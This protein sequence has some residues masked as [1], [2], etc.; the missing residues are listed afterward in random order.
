[1]GWSYRKSFGSGPF[2]VNF[3]KSG[4]SYSLG[5]KGA[6]LNVGPRGTFVN[7]SSHGISY[8]RK[9]SSPHVPDAQ[10]GLPEV[11]VPI[12]ESHNI[13][14]AEIGQ[15][16]DTDSKDFIDELTQKSARASYAKW[17]GYFPLVLFLMA[18]LFTS[19]SSQT[20]VV[21]PASDSTWVRITS[22]EG[23]NI[24][25]APSPKSDILKAGSYGQTFPLQDNTN[26]RWFK[27]ALHDSAGYL[28]KRFGSIVPVHHDE[29]TQTETILA[30]SYAPYELAAGLLIFVFLIRWL[31]K[32]DRKRFQVDL[33]YEMDEQFQKVYEQFGK[34]FGS[35]AAS[36]RIWQYLNASATSDWKRTGGAGRLIKR[37][38]VRGIHA[39]LAP[40]PYF[41]TNVHIPCIKLS[42][43]EFYFMP[44]RL[45]VKRGDIFAAV[46]YKNLHVSGTVIRFIEDEGAPGDARIVDQTWRYVN[47]HGGPDRRFNNNRQI[48]VCAYSEYSITSDTGIYE[49][50]TTS[51]QGAMDGFAEFLRQIGQLQSRMSF[52]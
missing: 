32:L 42:N 47:K 2:R 37:A 51:K 16:T 9:I 30:N 36:A 18:M 8:R 31:K 6:H 10:P 26:R 7:L 12:Y 35:F 38:V 44:E 4:I 22:V 52:N 40:L 3:S 43:L 48:P 20:T 1:M 46:F 49:V 24:R 23:V 27:I 13:A 29:E 34:H 11:T 17:F 25:K 28:N 41:N 15:L 33:H 5:V 39:H 50:I 14:S 21:H 45:L 19:F